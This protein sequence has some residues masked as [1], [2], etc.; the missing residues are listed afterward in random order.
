MEVKF[1]KLAPEAIMPTKGTEDAAGLDLYATNEVFL[2]RG[3]NGYIHTGISMA[4]PKGYFGGIFARSSLG[5]KRGI[6]PANCVGVIDSDYRGEIV[7]VLHND[8]D[9]PMQIIPGMRV[10]QMIIMPYASVHLTEVQELDVT[11]RGNG[12]F[13]S[14]GID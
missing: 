1:T 14:T 11:D 10:A 6:R 9:I 4:I 7:V 5:S 8:S 2:E 13:G 12:G 3:Q